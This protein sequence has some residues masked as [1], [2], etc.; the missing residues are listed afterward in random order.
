[1]NLYLRMEY[2]LSQ[3]FAPQNPASGAADRPPRARQVRPYTGI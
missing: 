1:M 3:D 2:T